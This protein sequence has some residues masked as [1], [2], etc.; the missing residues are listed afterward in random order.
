MASHPLPPLEEITTN[1]GGILD[2]PSRRIRMEDDVGLWK[3]TRGY[4]NYLLF[5]HRLSESSVGHLFSDD[6]RPEDSL[7]SKVRS[8]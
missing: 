8:L 7:L 6:A 4:Q 2:E 3:A 5:L 1:D